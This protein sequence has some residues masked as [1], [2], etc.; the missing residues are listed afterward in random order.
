MSWLWKKCVNYETISYVACGVLTTAVDFAAY[1][2]A[3]ELSFRVEAAQALSWLAA[4]C[5][6]YVGNKLVVFRNY[7][8][9]P[10][11][12]VREAGS[13]LTARIV[14]G[15]VTWV[16]MVLLVWVGSD[17]GL[18]YEMA[19]KLL[20]SAANLVLNYVFSKLWIFRKKPEE[21]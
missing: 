21:G 9:R 1:A 16:L 19:C 10:S 15:V 3:R 14:S 4:V 13:F 12:L 8:L 20:A 18:W 2:L 17:R 11:Y 6:A 7:N 5:F